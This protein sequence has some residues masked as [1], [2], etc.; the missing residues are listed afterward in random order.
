MIIFNEASGSFASFQRNVTGAG[1]NVQAL[2][3]NSR[4][5]LIDD[6]NVRHISRCPHDQ[7]YIPDSF[8]GEQLIDG[9]YVYPF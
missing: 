9:R 7:Y 5:S 8:V 1:C 6:L 4:R 3:R 2:L